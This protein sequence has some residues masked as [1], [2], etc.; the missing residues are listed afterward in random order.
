MTRASLRGAF[1]AALLAVVT[2]VAGVAAAKPE[3]KQ[4]PAAKEAAAP[5]TWYAQRVTHGDA[6][7][8]VEHFW[9][10]GRKLRAEMVVQ[11]MP[12]LTLVN[13][14][15][16][17]I[18]DATNLV[19]VAIRRAPEAV[20]ADAKQPKERPF[21]REGD[22]LLKLGGE[23]VRSDHHGGQPCRV[24]RHTDDRGRREVWVTD[25]KRKLPLKLEFFARE[26][27]THTISDY[28]DWLSGMELP[29]AFFEP[30]P[31]VQLEAIE[32]ADYVKRSGEGPVGPAPVLFS[33]LLHGK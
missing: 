23:L 11:G 33:P 7:V 27:G 6:P 29:D 15:R 31:R 2:G 17:T 21:G 20:A 28:I 5:D 25:D 14:D 4:A 30:D 16:Y 22:D 8:A 3:E 13:G 10:K 24:L 18:I 12:V 19:G 32:Y 9:S 1:V 26:S